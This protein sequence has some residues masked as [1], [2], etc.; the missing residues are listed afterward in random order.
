MIS[1]MPRVSSDLG[2][3]ATVYRGEYQV[4]K[5]LHVGVGE[6]GMIA[7]LGGLSEPVTAQLRVSYALRAGFL[8]SVTLSSRR[9]T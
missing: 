8:G 6:S 2:F 1:R 9:G 7:M 3:F 5:Q 4:G